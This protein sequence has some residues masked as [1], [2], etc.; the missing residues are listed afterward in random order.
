MVRILN[1]FCV[2]LMGFSILA[3]YHVSEKTRV[4]HMQL[5]QATAQIAQ[6]RGHIAV[7]ETEWQHVASPERIQQLAQARLGMADSSSV[8]LSSFEQLPRRGA[9]PLNNTPVHNASAQLP[10]PQPQAPS[11]QPDSNM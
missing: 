3:L 2:G 10:A 6:E 5:N 4:A 7:L 1:F 11:S 8:Q 9:E